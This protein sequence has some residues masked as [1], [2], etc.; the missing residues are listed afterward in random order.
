MKNKSKDEHKHDLVYHATCS[1]CDQ[2]Y[3]GSR[4]K[5]GVDEHS[6][7]DINSYIL[8]RSYQD[9]HKNLHRN[10]FAI[11]RNGAFSNV[12]D[13]VLEKKVHG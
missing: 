9:N 12:W 7:K 13:V 8:R 5:D 10:N 11:L 2:C 1:E 3:T 4:P 6:G